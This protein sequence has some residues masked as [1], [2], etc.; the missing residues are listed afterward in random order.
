MN[1]Y[2]FTIKK[3]GNSATVILGYEEGVCRLAEIKTDGLRAEQIGWIL[4]TI[5]PVENDLP[6]IETAYPF[7]LVES[8]PAD[9]SFNA[10]WEAYAY[11]VGKRERALKIWTGLNDAD[12]TKCLKSIPRYN[13]WLGT[14]FNMERLYPETYLAQKRYDNEFKI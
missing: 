10:F 12:R 2:S 6:A 5:P 9:L 11:K 1:K 3:S 4:K 14:K 8:M 7:I 13:Q